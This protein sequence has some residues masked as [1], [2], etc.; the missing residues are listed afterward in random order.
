MKAV[1]SGLQLG[2]SPKRY[3]SMGNLVHFPETPE[4]AR[5]LLNGV[6]K[7][8]I[9]VFAA[10]QFED[11]LLRQVHTESYLEFLQNGY[12]EWISHKNAFEEM[13]ASIRPVSGAGEY[14]RH[15]LG[16]AGFHQMDFSCPIV[17]D[18]W[19]TVR[20]SADTALTAASMVANG[21]RA[22]YALCRPPGHHADSTRASGFCYLNNTALVAS[23]LRQ[24]KDRVA[25][26]DIDVHHGNGTQEIF[27]ERADVLTISIHADPADY[28]PFYKGYETETGKA[29]GEGF[30]LN[31]PV[32]VGGDS[33]DWLPALEKAIEAIKEFSA[34]ALV[35]ALGLDA[36]EAD[37]LKGGALET[38]DYITM[39]RRIH[40]LALPTVIVQE[41][42]YLT[43]FLADN[44]TAFLTGFQ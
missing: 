38:G 15:I 42:G 41:G 9:D 32:P 34:G 11:Q 36:H 14:P 8:G 16:R 17:S 1:F 4:R 31:L 26:L 37:P 18:T 22:V 2:H 21:E 39:A 20:A 24:S 23:Y 5:R 35:V 43:P 13:M 44:L 28:Y 33:Y 6:K 25:V 3:L 29:E 12:A 7:A 30:N 27:Y 19:R 10:R 40:A